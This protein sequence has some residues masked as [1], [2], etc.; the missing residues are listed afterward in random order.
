M[1]NHVKANGAQRLNYK[2]EVYSGISKASRVFV[3]LSPVWIGN[4]IDLKGLH[5]DKTAFREASNDVL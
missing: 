3:H 1:M 5:G 2:K 4:F